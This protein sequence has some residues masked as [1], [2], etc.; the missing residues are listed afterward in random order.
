[1]KKEHE[2]DL[3]PI[4]EEFL[5]NLPPFQRATIHLMLTPGEVALIQ[6]LLERDDACK[7][8]SKDLNFQSLKLKMSQIHVMHRTKDEN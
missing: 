1:M 5:R 4:S 7:P 3:F 8:L 2:K 6:D